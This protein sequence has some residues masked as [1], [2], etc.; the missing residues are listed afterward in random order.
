MEQLNLHEILIKIF[1]KLLYLKLSKLRRNIYN[2][3]LIEL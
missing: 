3:N 1:D 2:I